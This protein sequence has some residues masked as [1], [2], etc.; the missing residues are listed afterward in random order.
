MCASRSQVRSWPLHSLC[1]AL[2][3]A[4]GA[5]A[6]T[7]ACL[8]LLISAAQAGR[9]ALPH[10]PAPP[11]HP[12]TPS[13]HHPPRAPSASLSAA[14]PPPL[15]QAP[16]TQAGV[17]L[18]LLQQEPCD[19]LPARLL[20]SAAALL[21]PVHHAPS[22]APSS[23]ASSL[24]CAAA[25]QHEQLFA[26]P[27]TA[28]LRG[29]V[30]FAS[31]EEARVVQGPVLADVCAGVAV[32]DAG[33]L[34]GAGAAGARARAQQL[35]ACA[36]RRREAE[37]AGAEGARARREEAEGGG[38]AAAAAPTTVWCFAPACAVPRRGGGME[39]PGG[40]AMVAA[41]A[42][43]RG[44]RGAA[45]WKLEAAFPWES[46]SLVMPFG[47]DDEAAAM[48]VLEAGSDVGTWREGGGDGVREA[49]EALQHHMALV[50]RCAA[51]AASS[52][53][54]GGGMTLSPGAQVRAGVRVHVVLA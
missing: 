10:R 29:W 21:C 11:P 12:A 8:A 13:S 53:G 9:A 2:L 54:E 4:H 37:A 26:A 17:S 50:A 30:D 20:R 52:G 33:A 22:A 47:G 25:E 46:F 31:G 27:R 3:D 51:A 45:A 35:A 28:A 14:A 15:D 44:G 42:A 18:L 34:F 5:H 6:P 16:L 48:S 39:G 40:G 38:D 24:P 41:G 7:D 19:P 32:L 23:C 49:R 36:Q 1:T 43:G